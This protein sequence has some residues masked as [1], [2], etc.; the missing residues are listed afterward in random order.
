MTGAIL[1]GTQ[2]HGLHPWKSRQCRREKARHRSC[3]R[4]KR[5]R[6]QRKETQ[7]G[8]GSSNPLN[9]TASTLPWTTATE[10]ATRRIVTLSYATESICCK[11]GLKWRGR[12]NRPACEVT[13]DLRRDRDKWRDQA[14]RL[15]TGQR[16]ATG[17]P[18]PRLTWGERLTSRAS[19]RPSGGSVGESSAGEDDRP[20]AVWG[21]P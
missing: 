17:K 13:E 16:P 21:K 8:N 18:P 11:S 10:G 9:C 12:K 4:S 2:H 6:F 14:A 7:T 5:A 3:A 15:L 19:A 20:Q 1:N